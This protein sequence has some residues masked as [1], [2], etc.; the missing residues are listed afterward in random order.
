MPFYLA[1]FPSAGGHPGDCAIG[2]VKIS[3]VTDLRG[4]IQSAMKTAGKTKLHSAK[5]ATPRSMP[6]K[7]RNPKGGLTQA[8]RDY[9]RKTEGARLK[10]GVT[11]AADTPDKQR[12]KG[13]FLVRMF[14][15]PRGPMVRDGE[16]TRLA[17]SAHAWGE[18]V[19]RTES[20]AKKLAAKGQK[21][22]EK[23]QA[24]KAKKSAAG[25]PAAKKPASK[26][27]SHVS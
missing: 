17:L 3:Q 1:D 13:S 20:A 11:G 24:G 14:S 8:G 9:Y 18:A 19:P 2:V 16:P 22:L 5:K 23:Y 4:G 26:K 10:P 6:A 15:H 12:R 7:G 25:K 21:L 27:R